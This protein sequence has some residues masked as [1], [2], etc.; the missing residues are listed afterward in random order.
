MADKTG[1][2]SRWPI[3][4][5]TANFPSFLDERTQVYSKE[6]DAEIYGESSREVVRLTP[7]SEHVGR[8]QPFFYSIGSC[9]GRQNPAYSGVPK[10][11]DHLPW[12]YKDTNVILYTT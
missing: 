12:S 6:R 8:G 3:T 5:R 11:S 4:I 9:A 10:F 7:F 2:E 1:T